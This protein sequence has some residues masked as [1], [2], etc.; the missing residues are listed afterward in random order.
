MARVNR[1]LAALGGVGVLVFATAAACTGDDAEGIRTDT[2]RLGTVTEVVEAP[3]AVSARAV[4]TV[5]S[6]ANGRIERLL[7]RDGQVV[8]AGAVLAVV[9]APAVERQLA[10]ARSARNAA[11]GGTVNLTSGVDLSRAQART[12]AAAAQAFGNAR[13]AAERIPDPASRAAA[14]SQLK[15]VQ[16]QYVAVAAQARSAAQAVSRGLGSLGSALGALSSAQ[17]VQAD[18]AVNLAQAQVDGLTLRAPVNG[19]VQLGGT[20]SPSGG[21]L[22]SLAQGL[23]P[24]LQGQASPLGALTPGGAVPAEGEIRAG[25]LV[26]PGTAVATVVDLDGLGLVAEVDETDV[27]LVAAGVTAVVDL[28]AVP[29]GTYQAKVTA[30]SLLPTTSA[31]GGVSYR[32]R[33]ALGAGT[34]ADGTV[35][36]RPRPGMSAVARLAVRTAENAVTVPASA[37][38]RDGARDT[39]WVVERGVAARRTVTVGTQ[40]EDLVAITGGLRP[41][42]R[43]VVSGADKV[44]TGQELR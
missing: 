9:D 17:R 13:K 25:A 14:L 22:S 37:L 8:R 16:A 31:R 15:A 43:V 12:D 19:T 40:G 38:V 35:A 32:V 26:A 20:S 27:L 4:A 23:P 2:V 18:A 10:Q 44:R 30:V 41:G 1:V 24:Q 7:V 21:D 28:D 6:T 11:G 36:P 3:A 33:L 29:G 42:D 34:L 39:V 5:T